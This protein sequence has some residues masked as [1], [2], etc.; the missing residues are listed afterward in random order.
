M[1]SEFET[2]RKLDEQL[3]AIIQDFLLLGPLSWPKSTMQYFL[4]NAQQKEY[5]LPTI[6]YPKRDFSD[7]ISALKKSIKAIGTDDHPAISFLRDTAQSYLDAYYILQGVGT[8]DVTEFS[9]TLYGSP[10]D[11][12]PGYE[13]RNVDVA[14]YFLRVVEDYSDSLAEQ[15]ENLTASEFKRLLLRQI[16]RTIDPEVDTINVSVDSGISARATA[17]PN[18]VKLRKGAK[19]SRSDLHQLF[20]HEVMTHTLTYING[21]KQPLLKSLG[22]N[23]PRTTAT[24]EGLAVFAE[25]MNLSMELS[26]LKR[27]A[28]RII[29]IDMAE[30][31]A[32]FIDLF[33]FFNRHTQNTEESYYST[34]RIFRGGQPKGGVIFYKDN[35]YLSGLIEVGSFFKHATHKGFIHDIALIFCGKLTTGD[36]LRLKP[37]AEQGHIIDPAYMPGWARRSSELAAH[38]AINDLTERFRLKD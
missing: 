18:Y 26:R 37:L 28:L 4:K 25:Y 24:Q 1:R 34:M 38:L 20:H 13:R 27:I 2:I 21:R 11:T 17:G 32:D 19:F 7:K 8:P 31:G 3:V 16:A 14:R 29:A 33:R 9:R 15:P 30:K 6:E 10:R 36:V 5:A 23:A 35:V 22:Y 12:I